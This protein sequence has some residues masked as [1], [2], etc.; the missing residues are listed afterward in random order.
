M[1]NKPGLSV[2]WELNAIW[3]ILYNILILVGFYFI[4]LQFFKMNDCAH[5]QIQAK[6]KFFLN[7]TA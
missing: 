5:K 3:E 2:V 7:I 6:K 4:T 1:G